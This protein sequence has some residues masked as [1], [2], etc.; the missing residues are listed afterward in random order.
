VDPLCDYYLC[1]QDD[2]TVLVAAFWWDD[3]VLEGFDSVQKLPYWQAMQLT[4]ALMELDRSP[5]G[6]TDLFPL[7]AFM[8]A[9]DERLSELFGGEW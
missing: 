8:G 1:S 4:V 5:A 3:E 9:S 7:T 2:E 6:L